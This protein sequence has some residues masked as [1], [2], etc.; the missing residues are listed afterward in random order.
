MKKQKITKITCEQAREYSI[1]KVLEKFGFSPIKINQKEAWFLSPFRSEKTASF[2]VSLKLNKWHD[3]AEGLGGNTL[4]LVVLLKKCSV[5]EALVFLSEDKIDF[6]FQKQNNIVEEEKK[7]SINKLKTLENKALIDYLRNRAISFENAKEY[8]E[9]IY[10]EIN[11]KKYFAISF[12]NNS[13]GYEIRNKYFKGCFGTK[14]MTLIDVGSSCINVF[15][16]FID[17][18]SYLEIKENLVFENHLILNSLSTKNK[19]LE[20]LKKYVNVNLYLD[21]DISG[22]NAKNFFRTELDGFVKEIL[23][24]SIIYKNHKDL[25]EYW[26]ANKEK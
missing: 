5:K 19:A 10:Y 17:F 18:L 26:I 24:F 8:C 3:H 9:E 21:N 23:D 12:K 22:N 25:N 7:Y 15:E 16:G 1:V 6:S 11:K 13:N 20:E 4:D 2:K 14:D